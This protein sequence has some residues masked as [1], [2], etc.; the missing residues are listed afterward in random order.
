MIR[1]EVFRIG[2]EA[3]ANAFRHSGGASVGLEV[4][5]VNGLRVLVQDIGKGIPTDI[6]QYGKDNHFGLRG[7][8]E[9]AGR[10]GAK[11]A[12]RSRL[13]RAQKSRLLIR[14][15]SHSKRL[16]AR[17]R[18]SPDACRDFAGDTSDKLWGRVEGQG[19]FLPG[20]LR[21]TVLCVDDHAIVR[22]GV[23]S[24]VEGDPD[25]KVVGEAESG[26]QA[27]TITM[28]DLREA[29][30][31][32]VN[33]VQKSAISWMRFAC[34]MLYIRRPSTRTNVVS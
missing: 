5:Y 22:E 24:L 9:R 17:R 25:L 29:N 32:N 12:V 27:I 13:G 34:V 31:A 15:G 33:E 28:Q 18:S 21:I 20:D 6:L 3:I 14:K 23:V 30:V 16:P 8:R 19:V 4:G 11:L 1:Y 26:E 10:I 2:S 7:I